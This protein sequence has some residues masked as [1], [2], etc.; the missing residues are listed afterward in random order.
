V[1][2][3]VS[4]FLDNYNEEATRILRQEALAAYKYDTNITDENLKLQIAASKNTAEMSRKYSRLAAQFD[5]QLIAALPAQVG[6]QVKFIKTIG[7]DLDAPDTEELNQIL[8]QMTGIYAKATICALEG[9]DFERENCSKRWHLEPE[10]EEFLVIC[11]T[12]FRCLCIF[13]I[14]ASGTQQELRRSLESMARL[15][16]KCWPAHESIVRK[17]CR[18]EQQGC[19]NRR[20]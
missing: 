6:R 12:P 17:V 18:T 8:G 15:V 9:C 1:P 19:Q 2:E 7:V 5:D 3:N 14:S 4:R 11:E 13:E 20:F 16:Q 10:I